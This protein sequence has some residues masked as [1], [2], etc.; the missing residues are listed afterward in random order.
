MDFEELAAQIGHQLPM[1]SARLPLAE[2]ARP[3]SD[4]ISHRM[5]QL[6]LLRVRSA[7]KGMAL[8]DGLLHARATEACLRGTAA[9]AIGRHGLHNAARRSR[10]SAFRLPSQNSSRKGSPQLRKRALP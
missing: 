6:G 4:T 2:Q 8:G 7:L 1:R 9:V 5:L 10:A 3:C